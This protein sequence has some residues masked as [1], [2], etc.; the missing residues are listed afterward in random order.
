[1]P[2][3]EQ[4]QIPAIRWQ[5]QM[6]SNLAD[7]LRAAIGQPDG[8]PRRKGQ[9]SVCCGIEPTGDHRHGRIEICTGSAGIK[10]SKHTFRLFRHQPAR[11]FLPH[12]FGNQMSD[13]ARSHH[14]LHERLRFGCHTKLREARR[15]SRQAED[16]YGVFGKSRAHMAQHF[17]LQILLPTIGVDHASFGVFSHGIDRKITTRQVFFQ[18]DFGGCMKTEAVIP[19]TRFAFGAGERIFFVSFWM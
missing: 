17:R 4:R 1:M 7:L 18:G 9:S 16:A 14:L 6:A 5:A 11:Q 3:E 19:M 12:T 15:K 10:F 2:H 8:D 13:F